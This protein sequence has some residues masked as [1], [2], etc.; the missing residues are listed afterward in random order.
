MKYDFDRAGESLRN[1][2][3]ELYRKGSVVIAMNDRGTWKEFITWRIDNQ[4]Y[5]HWGHYFTSYEEAKKDFEQRV[6]EMKQ[7]SC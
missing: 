3:K 1:G 5:C 4:G 6:E 7:W 2:A